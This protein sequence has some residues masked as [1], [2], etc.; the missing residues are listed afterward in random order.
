MKRKTFEEFEKEAKEVHKSKYSYSSYINSQTKIPIVCPS[1]GIFMQTPSSHLRGVG[2]PKCNFIGIGE[3]IERS[4]KIHGDFYDYSKVSFNKAAD[5]VC[6]V[7]PKHGE[8][9]VKGHSHLEGVSCKKC[10]F[11]KRRG[12]TKSFILK[13][14]EKHGDTY[15]YSL[16]SY[17]KSNLPVDIVCEKHGVFKQTPNSH[18]RGNGCA[19]C[20]EDNRLYH[21]PEALVKL[22]SKYEGKSNNLYLF[23]LEDEL[24]VFYKVGVS[25]D[26]KDRLSRIVSEHI[27]GEEVCRWSTDFI[28]C[29]ELEKHLHRLISGHRYINHKFKG[30]TECYKM[31]EDVV[32]ELCQYI[33][34]ILNSDNSA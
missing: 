17:V 20:Y 13:A 8:F 22:A 3:F 7:C 6:I 32:S 18:L 21:C 2:C 34:Y 4:I 15:D 30:Y 12:N 19:K 31:H 14:K 25:T 16:T 28:R 24:G 26:T 29:Y 1:H 23:K 10:S 11:E 9:L 33:E 27:S 5:K